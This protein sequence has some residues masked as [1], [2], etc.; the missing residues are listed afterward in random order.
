MSIISALA[1][2]AA[3]IGKD[4][5]KWAINRL[6][7]EAEKHGIIVDDETI[8]LLLKSELTVLC[9]SLDHM[10][11]AFKVPAAEDRTVPPL[12]I[13]VEVVDHWAC[14]RC[15]AKFEHL[16]DLEAHERVVHPE[17]PQ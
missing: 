13:P 10:M 15:D 11:A 6:R 14:E 9:L 17:V 16:A 7:G 1:P 8:A 12:D 5:V 2:V 3:A 4:A